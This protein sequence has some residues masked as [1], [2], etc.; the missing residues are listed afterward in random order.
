MAGYHGGT[1]VSNLKKTSKKDIKM[2]MK[3]GPSTQQLA[4]KLC[5][6]PKYIMDNSSIASGCVERSSFDIVVDIFTF[7]EFPS[8]SQVRKQSIVKCPKITKG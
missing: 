8:T 5:N 7:Q 3:R 1:P 4:M 2:T 6:L